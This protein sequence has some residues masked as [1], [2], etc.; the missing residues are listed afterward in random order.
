[1]TLATTLGLILLLSPP[2]RMAMPVATFLFQSQ[3]DPPAPTPQEPVSIPEETKTP[4]QDKPEPPAQQP[5]SNTGS[6]DNPRSTPQA[7]EA[8]PVPEITLPQPVA[9]EKAPPKASTA[10]KP[11][12]KRPHSKGSKVVVRNGGTADSGFRF[13]PV[14]AIN[15]LPSSSKTLHL[16]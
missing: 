9:P 3:S 11:A 2:Q 16:Y 6:T 10:K 7:P 1:M 13:L 12:R 15:K 14:T 4:Q 8:K 5:P